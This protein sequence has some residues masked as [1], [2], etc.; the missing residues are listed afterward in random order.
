M[1]DQDHDGSHIKGLVIN[2]IHKFWPS[3]LNVDGFLKFFITPIVKA[4]KRNFS[5]SFFTTPEVE[6]FKAEHP[7]SGWSYKY[8]K[9]TLNSCCYCCC[10]RY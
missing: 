7:E 9:G 3:L 1:A 8:Y 4:Q 6:Q 5:R 10:C 2:L